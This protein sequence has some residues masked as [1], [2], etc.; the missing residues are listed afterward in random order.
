MR[1]TSWGLALGTFALGIAAPASAQGARHPDMQATPVGDVGQW[2]GP[3]NYPPA[4]VRAARQGRVV[5]AIGVDAA[6]AVT[7]C[8]V[9]ESS[10]T[11][12][13][14]TATCEIATAHIRFDPA[15][16]HGGRPI[17]STYKLAVRW[18]LPENTLPVQDVTAGPPKD[19]VVEITL[20]FD[21]NGV[22]RSCH[23]TIADA[24]GQVVDPCTNMKPGTPT[25][26]RWQRGGQPVGA[27][28]TQRFSEHT[29]IDP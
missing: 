24:P 26:R 23:A 17:A 4:A 8:T 1:A 15:T 11:T 9:A 14:D 13:L 19:S 21:A 2:F 25:P 20:A 18:V 6:G 10:G 29:S 27:T 12:I 16:D 5:A 22:L 28:V 7:S 3:D